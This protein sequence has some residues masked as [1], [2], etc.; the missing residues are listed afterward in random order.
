MD[1]L[2]LADMFVTFLAILG[3]QKV[4]LSFARLGQA[5]D[6][7]SMRLVAAWSALTAAFVGAACALTAPWLATFFHIGTAALELAAGAVFF[8]YAVGI[9]LGLHFDGV[10]DEPDEA[11]GSEGAGSEG[12]GSEGAGAARGADAEH[13]VTS[14]FREMLLPFVVSPLGV[15]AALEESLSAH[16][17]GGRLTVAGA[18][19]AV[20]L[21]D[22]A[23]AWVFAPLLRRAHAIALEILSR[24]LGVLLSAVGVQL[25]L[26]GLATLG[27]HALEVR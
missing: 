23:C 10:S 6:V 19:A 1:S 27:V 17:W 13:P 22:L 15:A 21:I 26:Q 5:L 11:G 9:V 14:G 24:L 12:A 2:N 4:L 3:P 25:F 20:A 7:R 8:V 18:F 16:G